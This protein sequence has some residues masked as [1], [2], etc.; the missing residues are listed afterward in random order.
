M[1]LNVIAHVEQASGEMKL[2]IVTPTL[3][4]SRPGNSDLDEL[5]GFRSS[6]HSLGGSL[7][8]AGENPSHTALLRA[9][10]YLAYRRVT[11]LLLVRSH[12]AVAVT[13]L[14]KVR[15]LTSNRL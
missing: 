3:S 7:H 6:L 14:L 4:D 12:L 11:P 15:L 8:P 10:Q 2:A 5:L 9:L 13:P 1:E